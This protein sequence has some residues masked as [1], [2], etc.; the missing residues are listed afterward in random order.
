MFIVLQYG[1]PNNMSLNWRYNMNNVKGTLMV[2]LAA[3]FW[4]TMGVFSRYLNQF[5]LYAREISQIR[6]TVGL[7][8][9]GGYLVLVRRDLMKIRWRDL[10]C[11]LGTG[12]LS[13][14]FFCITYFQSLQTISMSTATVLLYMAPV[15][16]M[17]MSLVLFG[18]KLYANKVIA[19]LLAV[20]GCVLSSGIG[21]FSGDTIGILLALA[22]GVFYALYSIFSRYAIQRGY[23]VYTIVFY[24]FLFSA[25]GCSFLSDWG[26]ITNALVRT[27]T[28][29]ILCLGLGLLSGFLPYLLYSKGLTMMESSR[30]SILSSMEIVFSTIWGLTLFSEFPNALGWV[31]MALVLGAVCL[32]S[33][34]QKKMNRNV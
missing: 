21:G 13:L 25:I 7:L 22:S 20:L 17:L 2:I 29:W 24:T 19:L 9:I 30:V 3:C 31:G 28:A 16:V 26:T 5:G 32:L 15:Y 27:D 18:E 11:F 34:P 4:S 6:T 10:W 12:V 14:L 33:M 1:Y 8:L 23:H